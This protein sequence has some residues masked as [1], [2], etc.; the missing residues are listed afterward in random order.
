MTSLIGHRKKNHPRRQ[1][2]HLG[3]RVIDF[4]LRSHIREQVSCRLV[5]LVANVVVLVFVVVVLAVVVFEV[6]DVVEDAMT[7]SVVTSRRFVTSSS[8]IRTSVL[9]KYQRR[10]ESGL[11]RETYMSAD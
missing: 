2:N 7:P 10:A 9:H 8:S 5:T 3:T 1:Y 6:A 4:L 11:R